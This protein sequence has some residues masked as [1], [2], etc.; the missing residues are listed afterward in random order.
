MTNKPILTLAVATALTATLAATGGCA[1]TR[2]QE[3]VGA[4]LDDATLTTR[5]KAKFA[6][7]PTVS[8]LA[9]SVETLKGTVQ[10]SGFAKS[11]NERATAEKLA[12]ET[13]GV[14][15]VRNGIVVRPS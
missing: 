15:A 10:L 13:S 5:V 7:N 4:Y 11:E 14:V 6:D 2:S 8:A 9:I 3:S 1:V 12:R